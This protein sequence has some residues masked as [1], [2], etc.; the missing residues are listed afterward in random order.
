M[1]GKRLITWIWDW[2]GVGS[3]GERY[4]VIPSVQPVTI[5]DGIER[6][7]R[8]QIY[9]SITA[10]TAGSP[11]ITLPDAPD[12]L[13]R[14][15]LQ[16]WYNRS[17]IHAND[18]N[19]LRRGAVGTQCLVWQD[20]DPGGVHGTQFYPIIGGTYSL[21]GA[22]GITENYFGIPAVIATKD[23]P[24]T[25]VVSSGGVATG[26]HNLAGQFVD[27]PASSPVPSASIFT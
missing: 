7:E 3:M 18:S 13:K 23:S 27:V 5:V 26:N 11:T 14:L 4:T 25:M 16:L 10:L 15:W 24:L 9:A 2:L 6:P 1:E 19:S 22:A 20:F 12:G 21:K 17:I 8:F